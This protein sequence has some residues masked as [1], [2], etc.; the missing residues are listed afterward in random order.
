MATTVLTLAVGLG[1][2]TV[3]FTIFNAYVLRPFAVRDPYSLHVIGWESKDAQGWR[4]NWREFQDLRARTD[5]F[6]DVS[7]E[8]TQFVSS[9]GRQL[10]A[11]FVSGNYFEMLGARVSRGRPL[12]EFDAKAPGSAAVAVLSD[13]AWA[14][15][16]DRD[17]RAIGRT[18]ELNHETL[19]IVGVMRPGFSGLDDSPRDVWVPLTMYQAVATLD[20]FGPAQ[21]REM[22]LTGRLRRGMTAAQAQ[23]ALTPFMTAVSGRSDAVHA[24]VLLKATPAPI[25]LELIAMLSPVFAAF[26][27]VLVAA[28]AN[29]SNVMLAR[30]NARHREIGVRLSL[31]ASRG[32]VVRLLL[33]EGVLIAGLAGLSGLALATATLRAGL[34]LFVAMLPPSM[35]ALIRVVPLDF[36]YRVFLFA[37]VASAGATV[38]FA[39]V[40]ALQATRGTLTYA[41]RGEAG[42]DRANLD[43]AEPARDQPGHGVAGDSDRVRDA[44]AKRTDAQQ[45]RSGTRNER[46]RLRQSAGTRPIAHSSRR[47]GAGG[48]S[49]RRCRCCHDRQSIVRAVPADPGHAGGSSERRRNA[50]HVRVAGVLPDSAHS[51]RTRPGIPDG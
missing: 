25:S 42:G 26:G 9:A 8:R 30:A 23:A 13:Q 4:F 1:L 16:F 46:R 44:G 28:C 36:D 27:L 33:A 17:P 24:T 51:H 43:A 50:L 49:T 3:V 14:R 12:A 41:L 6:D 19:V 5:L 45:D 40:P 47:G 21:P 20:L 39:L 37:A 7:A 11:G 15:L 31:G 10:F 34:A 29:V 48:G 18:I 2:I 32:R 22:V 38:L 35:A